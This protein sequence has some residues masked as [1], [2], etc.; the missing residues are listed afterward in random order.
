[1]AVDKRQVLAHWLAVQGKREDL[2]VEGAAEIKALFGDA[3]LRRG[4]GV[5][6]SL[7]MFDR[8]QDQEELSKINLGRPEGV[9]RASVLQG[10]IAAIDRIYELLLEVADPT[11]Q[12]QGQEN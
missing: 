12:D 4:F 10:Q 3:T 9:A 2:D 5:L 1:M 6:W 11:V 7:I 8:A